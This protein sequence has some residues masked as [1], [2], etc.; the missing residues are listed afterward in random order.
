MSVREK[1][2]NALHRWADGN[3]DA[4]HADGSW[5]GTQWRGDSKVDPNAVMGSREAMLAGMADDA[6]QESESP[7]EGGPE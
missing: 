1:L 7:K 5:D 4:G 3:W 6:V 2:H